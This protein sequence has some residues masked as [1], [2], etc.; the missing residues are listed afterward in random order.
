MARNGGILDGAIF[1]ERTTDPFDLAFLEELLLSHP[2][3]ERWKF[4]RPNQSRKNGDYSVAYD[5]I[6][7]NVMYIKIDDDIV[8]AS[9]C[10][11]ARQYWLIIRPGFYGG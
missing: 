5:R 6:Q 1:V 7:D 10:F 3:Y 8:R 4:K 2:D 9:L 11:A